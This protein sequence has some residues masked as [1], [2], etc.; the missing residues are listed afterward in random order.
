MDRTLTFGAVACELV[1]S[2]GRIGQGRAALFD[3][4]GPH[5]CCTAAPPALPLPPRSP[6]RETRTVRNIA[7]TCGR[8]RCNATDAD[9]KRRLAW[10]G[11][12]TNQSTHLSLSL[13]QLR[14]SH[15]RPSFLVLLAPAPRRLAHQRLPTGP[16]RATGRRELV[17]RQRPA[18]V[19]KKSLYSLLKLTVVVVFFFCSG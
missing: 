5:Y 11:L 9:I 4:I 8:L 14:P 7:T 18:Y 13:N 15:G 19:R 1:V 3:A 10:L 2:R 6:P 12:P 17:Y 16:G